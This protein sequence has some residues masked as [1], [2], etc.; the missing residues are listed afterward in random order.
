RR[1]EAE[2]LVPNGAVA[3]RGERPRGASDAT[4]ARVHRDLPRASLTPYV[5]RRGGRGG[6]RELAIAIAP[7][8]G[9]GS[10][11]VPLAVCLASSVNA[12]SAQARSRRSPRRR[13]ADAPE[14]RDDVR[15]PATDVLLLAPGQRSR[16]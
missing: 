12:S 5:E 3:P 16:P 14:P 6:A 13:R 15:W 4:S 11:S 8:V 7:A 9:E 1:H 10:A 2:Q